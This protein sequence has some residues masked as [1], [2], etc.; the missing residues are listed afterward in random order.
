MKDKIEKKI[1]EI[2][3][4]IAEQA[5][6][7][8]IYNNEWW[9]KKIK[10]ELCKLGHENK[11]VVCASRCE[12]ADSGEWL[13]DLIWIKGDEK[14]LCTL[15]E[16][17][18]AME[19]EWSLD[20]VE[21]CWD[22]EKLLIV[23][24]KYRIFIFNKPKNEEVERIFSKLENTIHNFKSSQPGDRYLL[25]GFSWEDCKFRFQHIIV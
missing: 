22:F 1:E 25:A 7:D 24:S 15:V 11:V 9:T 6:E 23:R 12:D 8:G 10:S 18:L 14:S 21:I 16:M 20:N 5:D 2:L 3:E 17:P 19:C 4:K 13:L